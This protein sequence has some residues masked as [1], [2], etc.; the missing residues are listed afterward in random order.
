M[1]VSSVATLSFEREDG[2]RELERGG[3]RIP[4]LNHLVVQ[5][6]PRV[7][8]QLSPVLGGNPADEPVRVERR[9]AVE[10]E[11]AARLRVER[12]DAALKRVAEERCGEP[13]E[14]EIDVRVERRRGEREEVLPRPGLAHDAAARVH[15]DEANAFLSAQLLLVLLLEP[16]LPDLLA[17]LVALVLRSARAPFR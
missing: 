13:L 9:R 3:R 11:H 1:C 5:R 16:A 17:G 14:V 15:L 8:V 10:R 2:R 7:G 12:D 4:S 6:A